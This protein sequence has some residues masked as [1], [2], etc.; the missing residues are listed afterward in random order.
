MDSVKK[1]NKK[2]LRIK[3]QSIEGGWIYT[4]KET[5]LTAA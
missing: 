4:Y 2:T 5:K 3:D 1:I